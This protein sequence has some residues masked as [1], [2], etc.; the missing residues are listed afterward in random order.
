M[1][2]CVGQGSFPEPPPPA[3]SKMRRFLTFS[4][5]AAKPIFCGLFLPLAAHRRISKCI[6]FHCFTTSE[7][8]NF[9]A[10]EK[11]RAKSSEHDPE[12]VKRAARRLIRD[13]RSEAQLQIKSE[14]PPD[15]EGRPGLSVVDMATSGY[16]A[17]RAVKPMFG[18]GDFG[19]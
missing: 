7:P 1:G 18:Y 4:A 14:F 9:D 8:K 2:F 12:T 16:E 3:F 17:R 19:C 11:L 10:S 5:L 13:L 6:S 15:D